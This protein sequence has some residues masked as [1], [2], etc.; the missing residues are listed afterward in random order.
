MKL[1]KKRI[2]VRCAALIFALFIGAS[3]VGVNAA[4]TELIPGGMA[5]GV[6]IFSEGVLV[7]GVGDVKCGEQVS[8]PAKTAGIM[9]KD[10]ILSING[11]SVSEAV[12]VSEMISGCRGEKLLMSVKRGDETLTV[13]VVP[14]K[15]D[16]GSY[17]AGLSIRDGTA[18][19]GTV[20]Y[21]KPK[22]GEFAGLGH[23]ICD[24]ESGELTPLKRGAVVGAVIDG[25]VKGERG[26]PGELR[27]YFSA[28]K[29]GTVTKNTE[30]GVYGVFCDIP[31]GLYSE[32]I[33]TAAANEIREGEAH[34]L[35]TTG[36][37]GIGRYAVNISDIDKSGRRTKNFTVT[38]TDPELLSRTGGIV[39]GMSGSPILQDGKL[40][41][42]VTHVLVN[43]PCRGYGI[44]IENMLNAA[45]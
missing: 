21:I 38:V 30:C 25:V 20:T 15:S 24:T 14:T 7:V 1:C 19:I 3:G 5:F 37:D 6:R 12:R 23:G 43:D 29:T 34:I 11:E 9:E 36:E 35:C 27:G 16:D 4:A 22:T 42:A 13:T 18:G 44:F 32:P 28:G 31:S 2:F 41:G 17:K 39:Q 10:I 8:S 33:P 26:A 45:G 40:I